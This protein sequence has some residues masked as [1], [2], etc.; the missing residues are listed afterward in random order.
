M[1]VGSVMS[2]RVVT[3]APDETVHAA[4]ERM[5][6]SKIGSVVVCNGP[7]LAGILTERDILGLAAQGSDFES[8]LVR[9][10]MTTNPLTIEP[11][12]HILD[13]AALMG[14]RGIRHL[15]V[16]EG[17]NLHGIVGIRDVLRSLVERAWRN[18]DG[19]ARETAQALLARSP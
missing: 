8:L 10:A 2:V 11:D 18:H 15:P 6:E 5:M 19:E 7:R 3:V 12:V 1:L 14:E 16:V 13:A 9:D 17:E 4:I